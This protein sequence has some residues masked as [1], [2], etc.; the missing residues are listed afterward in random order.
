MN[1][2]WNSLRLRNLQHGEARI[3]THTHRCIR[4]KIFQDRS[5]LEKTFHQFE[6]Q[7]EI[8]YQRASVESRDIYSFNLISCL[9]NFFHLHFSLCT[10]EQ[11]LNSGIDFFQCIGNRDCRK[12][13]STRSSSCYYDSLTH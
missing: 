10:H 9:R 3:T 4:L 2:C 8:L 1:E 13:M 11:D 7:T 5:D 6:W 12:N